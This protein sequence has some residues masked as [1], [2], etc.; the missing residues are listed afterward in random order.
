MD[1]EMSGPSKTPAKTSIATPLTQAADAPAEQPTIPDEIS[2]GALP[3]LP[4]DPKCDEHA[5]VVTERPSKLGI[6]H[7]KVPAYWVYISI[8]LTL[9]TVYNTFK[10][11]IFIDTNITVD[12]KNPTN[13]MFRV[14]NQGPL[15]V[16]KMRFTCETYVGQGRITQSGNI[17]GS[18]QGPLLGQPEI[19]ALYAGG[20][21]TRDCNAVSFKNW[22]TDPSA[23]RVDIT[24]Y[25]T[26][27]SLPIPDSATRH[28][29]A[30]PRGDGKFVL[31]PD[32]EESSP[33]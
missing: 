18:G 24:T 4:Q 15:Q 10:P 12:E 8:V 30:R 7:K 9:A 11:H 5:P 23:L 25:F 2:T 17:Y 33:H 29:S 1:N 19:A 14:T 20:V 22:F 28:F 13:I 27:P 21:I 16:N 31:V 26:W 32:I 6:L 3:S